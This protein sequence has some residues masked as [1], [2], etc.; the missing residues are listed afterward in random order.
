VQKKTKPMKTILVPTDFSPTADN[1]V[2]FALEFARETNAG[3]ILMHCY[4]TPVLYSSMPMLEIQADYTFMQEA[5]LDKLKKYYHKISKLAK[6]IRVDLLLQQ[7]LASSRVIETALEKKANLIVMGTTGTGA[8][9]RVLIGSNTTRVIRNAPCMVLAIPPKAKY[10]GMKKIVYATDMSPA[11]LSHAR[12]I[13]PIAKIFNSEILFLNVNTNLFK[14]IDEESLKRMTVRIK[15]HI[16]YPKLSG[17]VCESPNVE[18]GIN[19]FLKKH[20][21]DCLALYTHHKSLL[22]NLFRISVTRTMS[23]HASVPLLVMHESDFVEEPEQSIKFK[24]M[25]KAAMESHA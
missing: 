13:I 10:D 7:G 11:N 22:D 4:E 3:I 1:A 17:F 19:L 16:R 18:N 5:A 25:S 12:S 15:S 14:E 9:E 21:A 23:V 8:V 24:V 2:R 6:G 20:K